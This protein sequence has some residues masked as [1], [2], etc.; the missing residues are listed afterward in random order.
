MLIFTTIGTFLPSGVTDAVLGD[1]SRNPPD[2]WNSARYNLSAGWV[3]NV[4]L[5]RLKVRE[6]ISTD[7]LMD[8]G[9]R[10]TFL[11][12]TPDNPHQLVKRSILNKKWLRGLRSRTIFKQNSTTHINN[13]QMIEKQL[14]S[15]RNG[16]VPTFLSGH[17]K[18]DFSEDADIAARA[19]QVVKVLFIRLIL[20]LYLIDTLSIYLLLP[21][22]PRRRRANSHSAWNMASSIPFGTLYRRR[23]SI[24]EQRQ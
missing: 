22:C 16:N 23:W 24:Y 10:H 21:D 14:S 18:L 13:V 6:S 3:S 2:A 15:M 17:K 8:L 9:K 12:C 4:D 11:N 19:V 7:V 1:V 5:Y 20:T